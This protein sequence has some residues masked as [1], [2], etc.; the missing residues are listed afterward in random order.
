[1]FIGE[2][3]HEKGEPYAPRQNFKIPKAEQSLMYGR[4]LKNKTIKTPM[5]GIYHTW[6]LY[7]AKL[8][9]TC[10]ARIKT[11]SSWQ[12]LKN[13][14]V[15]GRF[16]VFLLPTISLCWLLL[17]LLMRPLATFYLPAKLHVPSGRTSR[18]HQ[19][20]AVSPTRCSGLSY[21][22]VSGQRLSP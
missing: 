2:A 4:K 18:S 11:F 15:S 21:G 9:I 10:E 3:G 13:V 17:T 5:T 22:M 6:I 8:W 19:Q 12:D 20:G 16:H 1:M 14:T 7:L